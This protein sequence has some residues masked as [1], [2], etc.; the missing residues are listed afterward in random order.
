MPMYRKK[1]EPNIEAVLW[2]GDTPESRREV[3]AFVDAPI[4][5]GGR[6]MIKPPTGRWFA[7]AVG[8]VIIRRAPGDYYLMK[9]DKFAELYERVLAPGEVWGLVDTLVDDGDDE[10]EP[11]R[12]IDEVDVDDVAPMSTLDEEVA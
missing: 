7:V 11:E 6:L 5:D 1:P 2:H 12:Y 10:P 9:P 3:R 8:D 4:R